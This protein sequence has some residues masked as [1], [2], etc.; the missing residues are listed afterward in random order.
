MPSNSKQQLLKRIAALVS[1]NKELKEKQKE[2]VDRCD[3]MSYELEQHKEW[4]KTQHLD[5]PAQREY[6]QTRFDLATVLYVKIQGFSSIEPSASM[7]SIDKLDEI[8]F[9]INEIIKR[10][11][12]IKTPSIGDDLI[13]VG[14][15]PQKNMT[16]PIAVTLA[17]L[18]ILNIVESSSNDNWSI[19]LALHTGAI[20]AMVSGKK[21]S[22]YD[23]KGDT[24]NVASRIVSTGLKNKI[25][26][27]ATTYELI[28]ELFECV[29]ISSLP[30]K[31]QNKIDLFLVPGIKPE[32]TG[33]EKYLPNDAF[34][35]QFMLI[36]FPDLQELILDKLEKELP[37]FLFYHNV[38]HTVDVVTECEL[39]GWTEGL[40]DH[41][42]LLLKTAALFHDTG[43]TISYAD[44]EDR[45][46]DIAREILPRYG[47]TPDEIDEISRIIMA[48]KLPPKPGDL[49][50]SIICDSDL[51]YLGRSDFIP[52]SNSLY[53]ELKAQN[54]M[55]NINEWNKL[56]I[57]F[58]G[59]HQYFTQTAR[60][61]REVN[62]QEQI[63]RI[64][65]LIE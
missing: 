44:H 24:V 45:S 60:K 51:D 16:N 55:T 23:I 63:N 36:Q 49:L 32:Y 47:Y 38:K 48:T 35:T 11:K 6:T 40:N 61:L 41:E 2:L 21:Q 52:V 15:V 59:G 64:K 10:H 4:K 50:E 17:A 8:T 57:K 39:I 19:Q 9:Q 65:Q 42:L 18:E 37:K 34:R 62:K 3:R 58:I 7:L 54:K 14:G 1:E 29:Y 25:L 56:Q 33:S 43:H 22:K 13:Y 53:E 31:Y 30:V 27:S 28:K 5:E 12:L 26:V 46:V 20:T